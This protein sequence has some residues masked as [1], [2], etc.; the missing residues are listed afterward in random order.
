MTPRDDH[1]KTLPGRDF[2]TPDGSVAIPDGDD[3]DAG[4]AVD[5]VLRFERTMMATGVATDTAEGGSAITS[6]APGATEMYG[7]NGGLTATIPQGIPKTVIGESASRSVARAE[8]SRNRLGSTEFIGGGNGS[9]RT[10]SSRRFGWMPRW[11]GGSV[12][13]LHRCCRWSGIPAALA[14]R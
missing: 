2:D 11:G 3:V 1:R 9:S 12:D 5:D 4:A 7:P 14:G 6:P 8:D 10:R 13:N